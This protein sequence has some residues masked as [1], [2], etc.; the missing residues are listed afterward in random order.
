M[1]EQE[2][3]A[4]LTRLVMDGAITEEEAAQ[5]YL[6]WRDAGLD[7]P[8]VDAIVQ[9]DDDELSLEA[10]IIVAALLDGVQRPSTVE[11]AL[12]LFR[13][14]RSNEYPAVLQEW[15]LERSRF[16]SGQFAAGRL[17]L[18]QFSAQVN[19]E[20]QTYMTAQHMGGFRGLRADV[21]QPGMLRQRAY[22]SRFMDEIALRSARGEP[23]SEAYISNRISLYGGA[24]RGEFFRGDVALADELSGGAVLVRYRSLDDGGTCDPCRRAQGVYA[25]NDPNMPLPGLV[26]LG[27]SRCRC[28]LEY[29]YGL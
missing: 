5:I 27:G 18:E 24:G 17:T 19:R 7:I 9:L 20:L 23:F 11:Q 8:R 4:F 15:W 3:L 22:L 28:W 13:P 16:L 12:T 2:V 26:C 1:T 10:A 14:V 6:E 29:I 21:L 25:A